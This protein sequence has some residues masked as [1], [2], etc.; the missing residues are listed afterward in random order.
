[1]RGK[2]R[3]AAYQ[4]APKIRRHSDTTLLENV[5]CSQSSSKFC[6]ALDGRNRKSPLYLHRG[7][8]MNDGRVI[9]NIHS[10]SLPLP[11]S[12]P[13]PLLLLLLWL[14]FYMRHASIMVRFL[15]EAT[16]TNGMKRNRTLQSYRIFFSEMGGLEMYWARLS[17][18]VESLLGQQRHNILP[19]TSQRILQ[20]IIVPSQPVAHVALCYE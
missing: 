5:Q 17:R 20:N 18:V 7:G 6:G 8:K 16:S 1:M 9:H 10:V 11:P 4:R 14:D 13:L 2:D 3:S 19:C 15:D 12:T